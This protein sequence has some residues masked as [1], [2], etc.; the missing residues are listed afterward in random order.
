MGKR[1]S[2]FSS[3]NFSTPVVILRFYE[4]SYIGLGVARSLGRLGAPVYGVLD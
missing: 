1:D 4:S 3:F 2:L